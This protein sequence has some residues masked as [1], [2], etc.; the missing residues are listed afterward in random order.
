MSSPSKPRSP[1]PTAT[2]ARSATAASTSRISS[3]ASRS[4]R[5][6]ACSST[7]RRSPGSSRQ[8]RY[9]ASDLTGDAPADLQ[10]V[11]AHLS[12]EWGLGKLIDISD[13]EAR[14]D[15]ARL[16]ATMISVVAQSARLAD[17]ETTAV[18]PELVAS[19]ATAATRFLLEWR[20]EADPKHVQRDRHLL[21]LHRRA[22][23]ERLHLRGARRRLDRRGLRRLALVGGRRA[24]GAAARR[25][26][27]A[28]PADARRRRCRRLDRRLRQ[29]ICSTAAAA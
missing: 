12:G 24:L 9:V 23:A 4:R 1:S 16:S 19:G 21:D 27:G 13:E 3:A 6:G 7:T 25:R 28:R 8:Q 5:S 18:D 29:A 15:L 20:G 26:P 10:A 2:A 14:D 17:G 22:R 11:T